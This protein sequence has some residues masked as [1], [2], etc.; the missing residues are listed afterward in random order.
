M[1]TK[2]S[3]IHEDLW[4]GGLLNLSLRPVTIFI[5]YFLIIGFGGK[6]PITLIYKSIIYLFIYLFIYCLMFIYFERAR[7]SVW[8]RGWERERQ[9]ERG[10][11]PSRLCAV[12]AEP[13]WGSNSRTIRSWPEPKSEVG[14]L[15]NWATQAPANHLFLFRMCLFS[16]PAVIIL[17]C[18][19]LSLLKEHKQ[20]CSLV[21]LN[22]ERIKTLQ[23][24]KIKEISVHFYDKL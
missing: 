9:R 5:Y 16:S 17:L 23:L 8:E 4:K 24:V 11:M 7:T 15:T 6:F 19:I 3:L 20:L 18:A 21:L 14:H 1:Y 10:R 13:D 2:K 22:G 12:S